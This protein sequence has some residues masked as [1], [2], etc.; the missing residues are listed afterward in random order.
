MDVRP[1]GWTENSKVV[2]YVHG[3]AH[4]IYSA[5]ST[6]GRAAI[7]ADDTGHRII[8]VN[9]TVAPEAKF[10]QMS[11]EVVA[12]IQALLKEGHSLA[13]ILIY[14]DS[15]GPGAG[16]RGRPEN[17]RPGTGNAAGRRFGISLA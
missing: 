11:D 16:G 3:G 2:A 13:D 12:V 7:F 15:S 14:G 1:K 6:L 9:Y 8:S 4:I 10:S 17:A 5:K